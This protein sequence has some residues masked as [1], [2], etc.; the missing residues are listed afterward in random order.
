MWKNDTFSSV[1]EQL[2][3]GRLGKAIDLLDNYML[4]HPGLNET[5]PLRLLRADY[6]LMAEYW[7]RGYDDP[8]RQQLYAQLLRRTYTASCNIE[9][10]E[11]IRQTPYL[12]SICNRAGQ[13][14][15]DWAIA[16]VRSELEEFVSNIALLSLE[17]EHTRQKK[18]DSLYLQ[19]QQSMRNIFDYVWTG[20]LW[21][22]QQAAA[23]LDLLLSP[24]ID[25]RDQQLLVSAITIS[26][27]NMFDI[28][29]FRTLTQVYQQSVD[30]QVRQRALVGWVLCAD[31][32]KAALFD[33]MGHIIDSL[34]QD[35]HCRQELAELQMQLVLCTATEDDSRRIRN[36]IMPDLL[37]NNQWRITGHGI[38]EV[39]E[40]TLE[41]ILHPDAAEQ[42]IERME[43][44]MQKMM[45]MQKQGSDIYFGGFSQMKR[46]PFFDDISN[47]FAPF[48]PEHPGVSKI[49][50]G[51]QSHRFLQTITRAGA[52]C[53]SDKYSFVLAF[54][55]VLSH[56]PPSLLK[57]VED[58]EATPIPVGGELS[59]EE[60]QQPAFMRRLY[61]QN[62][63]RFFRLYPMR[64]EFVNPFASRH[65]FFA[66]PLFATTALQ[67]QYSQMAAFM[68]KRKAKEQAVSV[69]KAVDDQHHDYQYY[70]LAGSL[71]LHGTILSSPA[72][73][74][75]Y[76]YAEADKLK[77][78][79]ERT[80]AGLARAYFNEQ[81]YE[82]ACNVYDQLNTLHP[83][84]PSYEL[85]LAVCW[86]NINK[87]EEALQLLF[88]LNYNQPD[89]LAV[90]RSLAWALVLNNKL[91]QA[92]KHYE[93][94][95][96]TD[97][98][99]ATDHLNYGYCLW[100]QRDIKQAVR[101]FHLF[102]TRMSP[103]SNTPDFDFEHEF[104]VA[105]Q[106]LIARYGI[107]NAEVQ[108]MIDQIGS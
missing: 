16:T 100:F 7:L 54:Q 50:N 4:A 21:R 44:S 11:R 5:E 13:S 82:Q 8:E 67:Q 99:E 86:L 34:C 64:N 62:L 55:Q 6:S 94:L 20:R 29:K 46:F 28:E 12:A 78:G 101:Q 1:V 49:W 79:N 98:P 75:S 3:C 2:L 70:M 42:N 39:E 73:P 33:E 36:E 52:F 58:G 96:D 93:R 83:N 103:Q 74:A 27:M 47:W 87:H 95:V 18:A 32:S 85:S 48:Y 81:H 77:L 92:A 88:K 45:D 69:L 10:A 105:E 107:S 9:R 76:Y 24:T 91:E 68:I 37:N 43:E 90:L 61:L 57:L 26:G 25:S 19:H 53:D 60:Q 23:F 40:S 35:E 41:D 102:A 72:Y 14:R 56:M 71:A 63:Y 22:E 15:N 97:T 89:D 30:E 65:I 51:T 108:L 17:P 84:H 31:S 66:N 80:M 38:E 59:V 106:Q 104:M